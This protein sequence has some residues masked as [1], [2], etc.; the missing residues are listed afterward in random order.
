MMIQGK[1]IYFSIAAILGIIAAYT[2]FHLLMICFCILY[3]F[4]LRIR[5]KKTIFI[6]CIMTFIVFSGYFLIIQSLNT[7]HL[8]PDTTLIV[9]K[10]SSVPKIKGDLFSA[11]IQTSQHEKLLLSYQIQTRKERERLSEIP[12]GTT[13]KFNGKLKEPPSARNPTAFDYK[14]YL[15]FRQIH[16]IFTPRKINLHQCKITS[17]SIRESLLM[18]RQK[19]ITYV[20]ENFPPVT[21]S[22]VEALLFGERENISEKIIKSYQSLGII[23]ILAI[24]G[25][26]VS[27]LT[28]M[29]FFMGIRI[30]V[31]R[32]RMFLLLFLFIPVYIFL[33]G[34]APSVIRAGFMTMIGIVLFRFPHRLNSLDA[35]SIACLIMLLIQPY[36]LF[37]IGFQLSFI[38]SSSLIL[39]AK[40]V[41]KTNGGYIKQLLMVTMTAQI[42][43]L[44]LL[45]NYFFEISLLSLLANLIFIPLFSFVILPMVILSYTIHMIVPF[46]GEILIMILTFIIHTCNK[47]TLSLADFRFLTLTFGK[48]PG[49]ILIAYYPLI[50]YALVS[51]ERRKNILISTLCLGLLLLFHWNWHHFNPGGTVTIIDVGQGDSILIELPYRD[52]VYLIDTGGTPV[53]DEKENWQEKES[54]FSVG[55]DVLLPLLKGKGIREIDKLILTHGDIDHIGSVSEI[56]SNVKIH[57]IYFPKVPSYDDVEQNLF[58]EIN[59]AKIPLTFVQRGDQWV[60]AGI[61]FY[62]L[63]PAGDEQMQNNQSIVILTELGELSWLFTGDLEKEGEKRIL[64]AYPSLNIDV[65]KVGHHGSKTSTTEAF[66]DKLTPLVAL[67][68]V[69][70]HNRYHH[71]HPDVINCLKGRNITILRTDQHGAIQYDFTKNTGTFSTQFPYDST[72]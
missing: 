45:L 12:I 11:T 46:L 53:F 62:V 9:G 31:T 59:E 20:E 14:K 70:E 50:M 36:Y 55:E 68:S 41:A 57:E 52:S 13:C 66:L 30:G 29:I 34:A 48:P 58:A 5:L 43:V 39:S 17:S 7:S 61:P 10:I 42:I 27:L 40:M 54:A 60:E 69:G 64:N 25:L 4:Y 72:K 38:V 49:F 67:I 3:L 1:I 35:I 22:F 44:P 23:H 32:E 19:G 47:L 18:A 56:I 37:Q 24:S 26:H 33:A 16:W 65:L 21:A 63:A 8:K 2:S 28:G 6:G 15:T 71:P 51:F